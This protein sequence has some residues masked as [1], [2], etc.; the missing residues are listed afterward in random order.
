MF[1]KPVTLM[2]LNASLPEITL[3]LW[4][5]KSINHRKN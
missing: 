3:D 2:Q 5:N 1:P 4:G